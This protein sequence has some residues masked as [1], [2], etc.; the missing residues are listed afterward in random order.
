MADEIVRAYG[1]QPSL[2]DFR[3]RYYSAPIQVLTAMPPSVDLSQPSPG[4]PFDPPYD[5]GSLGSCGPN[6]LSS[7]IVFSLIQ[8]LHRGIMPSRLFI[9]YCTRTLMGT[10]GTDSGVDN[11]TMLKA[12]AQFGWC[13]EE[14]WPY[15]IEKFKVKPPQAAF[16]QAATR[17]GLIQYLRVQQDLTQMKAC[18]AGGD[19]F[20]FGFTVYNSMETPQVDRTGDVPMPSV[21][22]RVVGGHDVHFVGYD[23]FS[24]RF[25]FK[26]SWSKKWGKGGYGTIPYTYAINQNLSSDFWTVQ[27]AG[28]AP[29]PPPTP[30]PSPIPTPTPPPSGVRTIIVPAGTP[31][32]I[33]GKPV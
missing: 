14:L 17:S 15:D 10:V 24:Q 26:N 30:P 9:Y 27:A 21:F 11:R 32:T 31:I 28:L 16:D 25:K 33:D 22:D 4:E 2:P 18:L 5:Q 13:D 29:L 20:I 8:S 3:D 12:L 1:W 6:A 23:D 19:P 7:D